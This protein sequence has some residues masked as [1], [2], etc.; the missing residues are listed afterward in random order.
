M[1][2]HTS[3]HTQTKYTVTHTHHIHTHIRSALTHTHTHARTHTHHAA[4]CHD[5][6]T[7]CGRPAARV[8]VL[9]REVPLQTLHCSGARAPTKTQGKAGRSATPA[10]TMQ[11]KNGGSLNA[12]F[13]CVGTAINPACKW[14]SPGGGHGAS[15]AG[16]T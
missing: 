1:Y 8:V 14:P 6:C 7:S 4:S 10:Y 3:T 13:D 5:T 15:R 2:T 9:F 12:A 16:H 11:G